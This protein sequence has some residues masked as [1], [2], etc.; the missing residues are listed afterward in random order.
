MKFASGATYAGAW[1]DGVRHGHGTET[2]NHASPYRGTYSG[3]WKDGWRHGH[4]TE[5]LHDCT[6]RTGEWKDGKPAP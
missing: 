1:K 6:K 2:D 3:Q 4:G 5:T